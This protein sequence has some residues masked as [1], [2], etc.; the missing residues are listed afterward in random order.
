MTEDN[1]NPPQAEEFHEPDSSSASG[2]LGGQRS[3]P[4]ALRQR[5]PKAPLPRRSG[6]IRE[7]S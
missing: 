2:G 1:S 5:H 3:L 6:K 7:E 4:Q